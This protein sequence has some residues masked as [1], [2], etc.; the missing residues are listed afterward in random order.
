[1]P[2]SAID[3]GTTDVD[4]VSHVLGA[5]SSGDRLALVDY[6]HDEPRRWSY[7]ALKAAVFALADHLHSNG[8]RQD[9]VVAVLTENSAEFVISYF[10][11]LAAGG[12]VLPLDPRAAERD[13][14]ADV[15]GCSVRAMIVDT[16]L[17]PTPPLLAHGCV[18]IGQEWETATSACMEKRE[19]VAPGGDRTAVL[20]S[21]S[22]TTGRPKKVRVTHRNLTAGLRQ[23]ESLH[24]LGADDVVTC[25]GPLRHIYGMQMAMNP[26][27][28][29]GGTLLIGP[30]HFDLSE[31]LRSLAE[32]NV[33]V[34]Y[35]VPSVIVGIA[36]L[37]RVPATPALRLVVSG[38]GPLAPIAVEGCV[39]MLGKPVVQGFGMTEA[40]CIAFTPDDHHDKPETVGRVLPGTE[41]RFVDP[42]TGKDAEAGHPGELL[43]SGPQI[44]PGYL[45]A[46]APAIRD[47]D[48]WFHTGDLA[49]LDEDG[50]LRIVGR[51]KALI[52][53]K[54]FQV[55][56]AELEAVLLEHP[57]VADVL[58]TGEPDPTAGE[59]PKA[60]VVVPRDVSLT[61]LTTHVAARV[62]GYKRVRLIERVR[63]I[64]RSETGKPSRPPALRVVVLN[65]H[66]GMGSAFADEFVAAGMSVLLAGIVAEPATRRVDE[67]GGTRGT[68]VTLAADLAKATAGEALTTAAVH[69]L[70]GV[71]VVLDAW[72]AGVPDDSQAGNT[73]PLGQAEAVIRALLGAV[74][75]G[76]ARVITLLS[77]GH[78]PRLIAETAG[79]AH[80]VFLVQPAEDRAGT[81]VCV[82]GFDPGRPDCSSAP[83]DAARPPVMSAA[84]RQTVIALA[85]GAADHCPGRCFDHRDVEPAP[86]AG[87]RIAPVR[88]PRTGETG[89]SD[90]IEETVLRG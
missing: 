6:T 10:G 47:P 45:E 81:E 19:A 21:S 87:S 74:T 63:E 48:G 1:M 35:L 31:L 38:G 13:W 14:Q 88:P 50:F 70:G 4:L 9:D 72:S 66:S 46:S 17:W 67:S 37:P 41:M 36:A 30:T 77:G 86:V 57:E 39:R 80:R 73:A 5:V 3:T 44:S 8:V 90:S 61:E 54:G 84:A 15:T 59:V 64:P 42:A 33:A 53:Y 24:R 32:E 49:V 69:E 27:L 79:K 34:A 56:P 23:I 29:A 71:D 52:K 75:T 11:V 43:L 28:R 18:R 83:A 22:G 20:M 60:F 68:M 7:A 25:A 2:G 16:A 51:L 76:P 12:V 78:D 62:P 89:T 55:A 82:V 58:V 85:T 65:G 26:V 40:G